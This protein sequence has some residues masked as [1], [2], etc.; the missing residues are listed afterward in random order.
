MQTSITP[1]LARSQ[2]P[3][4]VDSSTIPGLHAKRKKAVAREY[5]ASEFLMLVPRRRVLPTGS[6]SAT[7]KSWCWSVVNVLHKASVQ[8]INISSGI[9]E[10]SRDTASARRRRRGELR[11]RG[12][13]GSWSSFHHR[14]NT[15][16]NEPNNQRV[17]HSQLQLSCSVCVCVQ[18]RQPNQT[19]NR[20]QRQP[21]KQQLNVT[22]AAGFISHLA[23]LLHFSRY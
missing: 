12:P 9:K 10:V 5:T 20:M 2:T 11:D 4:R 6:S 23:G 14:C 17:S 16:A 22:A 7:R 1:G 19:G 21:T 18:T 3:I 13:R 8:S 15:V